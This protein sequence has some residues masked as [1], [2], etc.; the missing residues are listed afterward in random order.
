MNKN[1]F[2]II[3]ILMMFANIAVGQSVGINNPT[4]NATSALDITSTN[5]GLLIPRMTTAQRIAISTPAT[6][7]LVYDTSLNLFYYFDGT[8]WRPFMIGNLDWLLAGNAGTSPATNFIGTTDAQ[9]LVFR[10]NNV[11]AMR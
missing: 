5:K 7:L 11:E 6:G 3:G 10:T 2:V 8:A 1:T 9:P 4:P